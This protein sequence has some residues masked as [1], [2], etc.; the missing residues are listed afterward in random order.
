MIVIVRVT[1][2]TVRH[3]AAPLVIMGETSQLKCICVKIDMRNDEKVEERI[4][5]LS[6]KLTDLRQKSNAGSDVTKSSRPASSEPKMNGKNKS[7]HRARSV[8]CVTRALA[9]PEAEKE[10]DSESLPKLDRNHITKHWHPEDSGKK[11]LNNNPKTEE[12][13]SEPAPTIQPRIAPH[14]IVVLNLYAVCASKLYDSVADRAPASM[15]PEATIRGF[16][17]GETTQS[18]INPGAYERQRDYRM[19]DLAIQSKY[20]IVSCFRGSTEHYSPYLN[21]CRPKP[22]TSP[23]NVLATGPT[24]HPNASPVPV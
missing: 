18:I 8:V 16:S 4:A 23:N 6:R 20:C 1:M 11:K 10:N 12:Y 15:Y 5:T 24:E 21:N 17:T 2:K 13:P 14:W 7:H 19:H 3:D 9:S 22:V